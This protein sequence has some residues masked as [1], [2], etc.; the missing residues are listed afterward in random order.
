MLGCQPRWWIMDF[1]SLP[2][3][4]PGM[5]EARQVEDRKSSGCGTPGYVAPEL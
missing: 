4:R 5:A 1:D 3:L 2:Q